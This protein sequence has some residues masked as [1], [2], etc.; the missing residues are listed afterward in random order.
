[1]HIAVIV[2]QW[3]WCSVFRVTTTWCLVKPFSVCTFFISLHPFSHRT[4]I[5]VSFSEFYF[6]GFPVFVSLFLQWYFCKFLLVKFSH[7]LDPL[8]WSGIAQTCCALRIPLDIRWKVSGWTAF[9]LSPWKENSP[10]AYAS[11]DKTNFF[12][13]LYEGGELS[14]RECRKGMDLM[15]LLSRFSNQFRHE[16]TSSFLL[17]TLVW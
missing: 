9:T 16:A 15:S 12:P 13:R 4:S 17:W 1:M 5:D 8:F 11:Y 2:S 6:G 10:E 7:T 14:G 3:S